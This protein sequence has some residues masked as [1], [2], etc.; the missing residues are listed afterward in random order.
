MKITF[1]A[2]SGF[3]I[4]TPKCS[5]IFDYYEDPA[6]VL[7]PMLDRTRLPVIALSSHSHPDHFNPECIM[8]K[9]ICNNIIYVISNDIYRK[10]RRRIDMSDFVS[11]KR[12]ERR[13]LGVATVDT[14]GSTD[15]GLSYMLTVDGCRIFHA[16]DLNNWHWTD[17]STPGEVRDAE[18]RFTAELDRLTPLVR[19][20]DV[21]MFPVDPRV[22]T[23]YDRGARQF[24]ERIEPKTF[25]PMHWWHQFD[26][27]LSVAP[28]VAAHGGRLAA[29]MHDGQ[30]IVDIP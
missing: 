30:T 28:V 3:L 17:E 8:W 27:T 5:L 15:I 22:G 29:P 6:G 1:V 23:D 14:F 2:H 20:A 25:V 9:H 11:L 26:K 19:G 16:G 21:A 7:A 13:D 12:Y 4:E 24:I 10:Y 18:N